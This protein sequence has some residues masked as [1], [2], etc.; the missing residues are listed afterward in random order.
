MGRFSVSR[1][2][3]LSSPY[4]GGGWWRGP[5]PTTYNP[6][7]TSRSVPPTI[8]LTGLLNRRTG[9]TQLQAAQRAG[10]CGPQEDGAPCPSLPLAQTS[11]PVPPPAPEDPEDPEDAAAPSLGAVA[12]YQ[13]AT[14]TL[15]TRSPRRTAVE[16][17]R[18]PTAR[19]QRGGRP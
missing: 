3:R 5:S 16:S 13:P 2:Q 7:L 19:Q 12:T 8:G 4:R 15:S 17:R 9:V 1:C 10:V 6:L 11:R 18:G 14:P